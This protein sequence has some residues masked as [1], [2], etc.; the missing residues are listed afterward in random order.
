[1][2]FRST[3]AA[4][5]AEVILRQTLTDTIDREM[6]LTVSKATA[7]INQCYIV[8]ING[9]DAGGYGRSI[10]V[11]PDGLVL[12]QAG[13]DEEII[14][15]ELDLD[16]VQRVR[17]RGFKGLAQTLKSF[18]DRSV[19]FPL[20]QPGGFDLSYLNALGPLHVP[21]RAPARPAAASEAVISNI[22]AVKF[23]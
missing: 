4:M 8:D 13:T 14:P 3:L 10:I 1:M 18:R 2:L 15:L 23:G 19:A 5:G 7:A 12:H 16:K 21:V 11:D 20:Y 17:E 9:L 22:Q 6:E